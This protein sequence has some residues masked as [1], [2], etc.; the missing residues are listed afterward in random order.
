[1]LVYTDMSSP[2]VPERSGFDP[3]GPASVEAENPYF[4]VLSQP[5]DFVDP[6]TGMVRQSA[7]EGGRMNYIDMKPGVQ[8]VADLDGK[9]TLLIPQQRFVTNQVFGKPVSHY[10]LPGGGVEAHD[11][12]HGI[13]SDE[14]AVIEAAR[15]EFGE[16]SGFE[17]DDYLLVAS[18]HGLM[19]HSGVSLHH[20][21]TVIARGVKRR[22]DGA[23]PEASEIIHPPEA[24]TW[25]ETRQMYMTKDGLIIPNRRPI[26]ISSANTV[27]S[28]V[29]AQYA[30]EELR[31][32]GT[33]V[34]DLKNSDPQK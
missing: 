26:I 19:T 23:L 34:I 29:I 28:L 9:G 12:G 10:E 11:T 6:H 21:F 25:G 7:E 27:T 15:R 31:S 16:E 1:M 18:P 4:K 33:T 30:L 20:T 3:K 2:D 22:T 5:M 17:A 24:F 8:I 32:L 13:E 14:A